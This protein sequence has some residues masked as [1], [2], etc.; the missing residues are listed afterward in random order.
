MLLGSDCTVR[1]QGAPVDKNKVE[2]KERKSKT[3]LGTYWLT[4]G[5]QQLQQMGHSDCVHRGHNNVTEVGIRNHGELCC[6]VQ[7]LLPA[8]LKGMGVFRGGCCIYT[9]QE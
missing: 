6:R 2:S 1:G 5:E 3:R 8:H 7:P 9:L 4:V